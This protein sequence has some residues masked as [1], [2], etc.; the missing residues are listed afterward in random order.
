VTNP[1]RPAL[2]AKRITGTKP[3]H[4]TR[5]GSS[6]LTDITDRLCDNRTSEDT[7]TICYTAKHHDLRWIQA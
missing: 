2:C 6:N 1:A 5:F 7:F 4:D 3:A